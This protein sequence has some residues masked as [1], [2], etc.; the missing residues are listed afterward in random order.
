MGD[1]IAWKTAE[2]VIKIITAENAM[3]AGMSIEEAAKAL[4]YTLTK[5]GMYVKDLT[6]I[7]VESFF[8]PFK[9]TK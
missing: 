6:N 1:L 3:V 8:T 5:S 2:E 9:N 4:G 7:S